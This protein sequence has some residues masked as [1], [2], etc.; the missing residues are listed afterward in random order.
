MALLSVLRRPRE[1]EPELQLPVAT[2]VPPSE[3]SET[4]E[5]AEQEDE[6]IDDPAMTIDVLLGMDEIHLM[7]PQ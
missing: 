4:I 6:M 3:T 5:V 1:A 7:P 2:A